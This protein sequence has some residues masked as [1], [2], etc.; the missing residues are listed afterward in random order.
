[1]KEVENECIEFKRQYT[2]ETNKDIVA[3]ANSSGGI[4][5]IGVD[6]AG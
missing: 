4:V 2:K 5:R 1:M 6:D 3:F